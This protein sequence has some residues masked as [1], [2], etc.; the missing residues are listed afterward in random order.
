MVVGYTQIITQV[1]KGI[2][3]LTDD[4]L[5]KHLSGLYPLFSE[6]IMSES[7]EI[8]LVLKSLFVRIGAMKNI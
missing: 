7:N 1:L 6:M 8:R 5:N 4:Q 2:Q 3:E